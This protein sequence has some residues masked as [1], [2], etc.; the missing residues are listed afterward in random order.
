MIDRAVFNRQIA[1]LA[2]IHRH[3]LSG[4]TI[5]EYYALLSPRMTT[6]QFVK[7]ARRI[8]MSAGGFWPKPAEFLPPVHERLG[9]EQLALEAKREGLLPAGQSRLQ[10]LPARAS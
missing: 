10:Q 6:E 7:M 8:E 5:D 9:A 4:P 3:V 2:E 1:V